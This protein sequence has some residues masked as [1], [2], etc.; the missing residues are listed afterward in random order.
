MI[1][2]QSFLH[3]VSKELLTTIFWTRWIEK[4]TYSITLLSK[5]NVFFEIRSV[6]ND[7]V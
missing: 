4:A 7:A 6:N 1:L 5:H 3:S 2:D